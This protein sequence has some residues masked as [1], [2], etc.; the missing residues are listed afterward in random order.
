[1]VISNIIVE[2]TNNKQNN[3]PI[4]GLYQERG[5]GRQP[6]GITLSEVHASREFYI[7]DLPRVGNLAQ[8]PSWKVGDLGM[9]DK[10][11]SILEN[12]Q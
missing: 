9:S 6:T 10:R 11:S 1:M 2:V 5:G 7:L 12:T 3:A 4:N 8:P